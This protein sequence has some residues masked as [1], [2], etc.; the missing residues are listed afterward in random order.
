LRYKNPDPL[1]KKHAKEIIDT[2]KDFCE[3]QLEDCIKRA[4]YNRRWSVLGKELQYDVYIGLAQELRVKSFQIN[5]N[6]L[7]ANDNTD[8][9]TTEYDKFWNDVVIHESDSESVK[10]AKEQLQDKLRG[11]E[12]EEHSEDLDNDKK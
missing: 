8:A 6:E 7:P 2:V 9:L 1:E 3:E 10:K 12:H 5:F 11:I 4:Y